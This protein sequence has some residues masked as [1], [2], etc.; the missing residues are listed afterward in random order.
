[1][2]KSRPEGVYYRNP[3]K[4]DELTAF[5]LLTRIQS[6]VV[7]L[8]III[9]IVGVVVV[10]L[11]INVIKVIINILHKSISTVLVQANTIC[12]FGHSTPKCKFCH[13]D[14]QN[15]HEFEIRWISYANSG[16]QNMSAMRIYEERE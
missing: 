7:L 12:I 9:I 3:Y 13:T 5:A 6:R 10:V 14:M 4:R 15:K 1:M 8:L 2:W 16:L 11:I